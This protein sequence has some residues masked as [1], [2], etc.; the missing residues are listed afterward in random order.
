M[1]HIPRLM[2]G[3]ASFKTARRLVLSLS[4]ATMLLVGGAS[5]SP[6]SPAATEAVSINV[7]YG[8]TVYPT[9]AC[10]STGIT[11]AGI[12]RGFLP[13]TE[14]TY[15]WEIKKDGLPL[16][17][18]EKG[19]YFTDRT[20]YHFRLPNGF[21]QAVDCGPGFYTIEMYVDAYAGGNYNLTYTGEAYVTC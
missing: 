20:G 11:W 2:R 16:I 4:A 7:V 14:I 3:R 9:I 10:T 8:G 18:G 19:G 5:P 21:P 15:H 6:A 1:D 17:D 13:Y 12:T